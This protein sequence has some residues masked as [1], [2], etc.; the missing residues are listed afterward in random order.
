VFAQVLHKFDI[1]QTRLPIEHPVS[2]GSM[3][4]SLERRL[5]H[6]MMQQCAYDVQET[7]KKYSLTYP[8]SFFGLNMMGYSMTTAKIKHFLS[9]I[10]GNEGVE[11]MCHPGFVSDQ[12]TDGF[13]GDE[14]A[15]QFSC[16][17]EREHEMM[18][19]MSDDLLQFYKENHIRLLT[20]M[21]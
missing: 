3:E 18:V 2:M 12:S 16:S 6:D 15:D 20:S 11:M 5:F 21:Q 19:L 17:F 7:W 8:T 13:V 14:H 9:S 4:M 1:T 10:D